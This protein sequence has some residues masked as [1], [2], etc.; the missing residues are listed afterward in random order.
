M[1]D[2]VSVPAALRT[3]SLKSEDGKLESTCLHFANI[4]LEIFHIADWPCYLLAVVTKIPST[5]TNL[6]AHPGGSFSTSVE[7]E[8]EVRDETQ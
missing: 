1:Y 3:L 4:F 8:V 2:S 5:Y 7:K 6:F